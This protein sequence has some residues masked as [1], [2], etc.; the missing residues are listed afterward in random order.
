M[1]ARQLRV[2]AL[3]AELGEILPDASRRLGCNSG[4]LRSE[5]LMER[6]GERVYRVRGC[7]LGTT[8]V[9]RSEIIDEEAIARCRHT[10]SGAEI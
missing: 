4:Q 10:T 5:R 7:D 9:C 8:Y 6:D 3:E 2:K 1:N